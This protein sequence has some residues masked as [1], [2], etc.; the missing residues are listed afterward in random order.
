MTAMDRAPATIQAVTAAVVV[1]LAGGV[2]RGREARLA[3]ERGPHYVGE[4]FVMQVTASGFDEEPT[5]EVMLG[6]MPEGLRVSFLGVNPSVS[7]SITIVNGRRT[8]SRRVVFN[9]NYRLTGAR[10]GNVQVPAVTV[11]QGTKTATTNALSLAI[12]EI[13]KDPDMRIELLLPETSI[14]PGQR[15]KVSVRWWYAGNVSDINQL[16]IYSPLFDKF[17]FQDEPVRRGDSALPLTGAKGKV[18]VKAVVS[19]Q[20]RDGKQYMVATADRILV[21]DRAGEYVLDPIIVN[22]SKVV[23]WRRDV[24]GDRVPA[25]VKRLQAVGKP[26]RLTVKPLPLAGRPESFAGAIGSG[27]SL[28]V[29]A[30]STVVKL[31]DPIALTL[32]LRG[33]GKLDNA[34]LPPLFADGKGLDPKQFSVPDGQ[35]AGEVTRDGKQFTLSVRVTDPAVNQIPPMAYSWFDPEQGKYVTT[36]SDPIALQVGR[37]KIVSSGDVVSTRANG[38]ANPGKAP[39]AAAGDEARGRFDTSGADLAIVTA[40]ALLLADVERRF[41]GATVPAAIYGLSAALVVVM[42]ILGR[43]ASVDPSVLAARRTIHQQ[44]A[45]LR[46]AGRLAGG[47]RAAAVAAA[48]RALAPHARAASRDELD[49]IVRECD[50][51]AFARSERRGSD[52]DLYA[53]A[54]ALAKE[55]Q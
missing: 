52:G 12:Q 35:V 25:A 28:N 5:P 40:P 32:T 31:G 47:E 22:V 39:R 33:D 20:T 29:R 49:R 44:R 54:L 30:G 55:M 45:K 11:K 53:R 43:R 38:P 9:F 48:L 3:A 10:A 46:Q 23:Q 18:Q 8:E 17:E 4:P 6:K 42:F 24:F 26:V 51:V 13:E 2:A 7:T 41:G 1:L 27:F 34:S 15:A 19:R 21:A 14:Y 50:D 36:L 37:A 16:T